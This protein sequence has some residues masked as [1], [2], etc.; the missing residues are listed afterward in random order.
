MAFGLLRRGSLAGEFGAIWLIAVAMN[1]AAAMI[2][3]FR[4][5][6]GVQA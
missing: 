5:G 6:D 2:L 3:A 4:N 1:L